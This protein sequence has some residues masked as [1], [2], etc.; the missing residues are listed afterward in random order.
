M[1]WGSPWR[2]P[3]CSTVG[4]GDQARS[5]EVGIIVVVPSGVGVF[6]VMWVCPDRCMQV[7]CMHILT[8]SCMYVCIPAGVQGCVQWHV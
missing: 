6:S 1:I 5:C 2:F 8:P 7:F 3:Y 4:D